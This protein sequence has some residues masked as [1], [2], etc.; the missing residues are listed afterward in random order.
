[1]KNRRTV[2]QRW[3]DSRDVLRAG[4]RPAI[5]RELALRMEANAQAAA[6]RADYN[7]LL[8]TGDM[9]HARQYVSDAADRGIDTDGYPPGW[10][11]AWKVDGSRYPSQE[12]LLAEVAK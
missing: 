11:S 10:P 5:N 8:A 2:G 9:N 7:H 3:R 1:M 12:Q 6:F 4:G